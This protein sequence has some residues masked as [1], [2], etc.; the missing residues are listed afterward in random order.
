MIR[1]ALPA[2]LPV[3]ALLPHRVREALEEVALLRPVERK[4][5]VGSVRLPDGIAL[6]KADAVVRP[7]R[8]RNIKI[9][10]L[11]R[12]AG[13]PRV[14]P[15]HTCLRQRLR[16]GLDLGVVSPGRIRGRGIRLRRFSAHVWRIGLRG[17]GARLRAA[18]AEQQGET[19]QNRPQISVFHSAFLLK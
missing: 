16:R 3:G 12:A 10:A 1:L 9:E 19:E 11:R 2:Q 15:E 6:V 4:I 18:A 13:H 8:E 17:V 7:Y 5:V 14:V